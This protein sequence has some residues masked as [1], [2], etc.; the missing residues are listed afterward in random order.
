VPLG[1]ELSDFHD[2]ALAGW[3]TN[4]LEADWDSLSRDPSQKAKG[5]KKRDEYKTTK[6]G[7]IR[8]TEIEKAYRPQNLLSPGRVFGRKILEKQK[9]NC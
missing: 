9:S 8:N 7:D 1:I 4:L 6:A 2:G 5:I 3:L